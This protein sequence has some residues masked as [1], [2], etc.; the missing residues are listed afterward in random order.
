[1][2]GIVSERWLPVP[3]DPRYEVSD[4]GR[5][6]RGA[7]ELTPRKSD[8]GYLCIRSRL[9]GRHV[10]IFVS[11]AVAEA[12]I[13]PAP[14]ERHRVAH[15]DGVETNNRLDNLS[16]KLPEENEADKKAHGTFPVR[17]TGHQRDDHVQRVFEMAKHM[18]FTR[19]GKELGLHRS[20]VSRIVRG[21]RRKQWRAA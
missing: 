16:W 7:R 9:A 13:G 1:V 17:F 5:I 19:I 8:S 2:R 3:R 15:G 21:L 18:S 14:S 4:L 20:S 12:F 11:K 6:R 10:V